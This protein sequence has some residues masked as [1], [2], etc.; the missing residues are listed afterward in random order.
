MQGPRGRQAEL[1]WSLCYLVLLLH[2]EQLERERRRAAL[3]RR[4]AF[5]RPRAAIAHVQDAGTSWATATTAA[6][7]FASNATV[8]N[9]IVAVCGISSTAQ[10]ASAMSG[11]C[12]TSGT[13]A[14]LHVADA[15]DSTGG[16][17]ISIWAG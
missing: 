8:G 4:L 6:P 5:W 11:V 14:W 15:K 7:S 1:V 16:K 9:L 12:P 2:L 10:Y 3:L 13:G 17:C